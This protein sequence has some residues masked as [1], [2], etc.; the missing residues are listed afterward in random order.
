M[1]Q[2]CEGEPGHGSDGLRTSCSGHRTCPPFGMRV[3]EIIRPLRIGTSYS[4]AFSSNGGRLATVGRD[5]CVWDIECRVKITRS[6]P[7][8][9]PSHAGFAP[10]G[11]TLAVKS[12]SGRIAVIAAATGEMVVDFDNASDGEGTNVLFSPGGDFLV[13]GSWGGRLT[14]RRADSGAREFV[15]DFPGEMI[16][17]IHRT[18]NGARWIVSHAPKATTGDRP[19]A[20]GYFSVWAWPFV[21]GRFDILAPRIPFVRASALSPDGE[22]LAVVH[23]APPNVLWV[24]RT[25]DGSRVAT[26]SVD[27]G[28]TPCALAWS[29]DGRLVGS[30]Q[31]KLIAFYGWPGLAFLWDVPIEFPSDVAFSPCGKVVALGSWKSGRVMNMNSVPNN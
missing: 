5:V 24:L 13:D 16:R 7:F 22:H 26:V 3:G 19:P 27:V 6:R 4:V 31:D 10:D 14:V 30:A 23:G 1:A 18:Q 28:G 25:R 9:H 20:P 8:S 29:A 12:T 2:T 15:Q 11:G 21:A 17:A